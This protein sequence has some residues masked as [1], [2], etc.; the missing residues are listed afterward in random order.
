ME[1]P[2]LP[3][4]VIV[5]L[6]GHLPTLAA[7]RAAMLVCHQWRAAHT[8]LRSTRP[9]YWRS[10][11]MPVSAECT[12]PHKIKIRHSKAQTYHIFT[13]AHHGPM[14]QDTIQALPLDGRLF[15]TR[16]SPRSALSC[17]REGDLR[18]PWTW[19]QPLLFDSAWLLGDMQQLAAVC[20]KHM[21]CRMNDGDY[22]FTFKAAKTAAWKFHSR[23]EIY[24]KGRVHFTWRKSS[25]SFP[26]V[27]RWS[28]PSNFVRDLML[29]IS[30]HLAQ[31]LDGT[32]EA[33]YVTQWRDWADTY[34]FGLLEALHVYPF[35]PLDMQKEEYITLT[36]LS[37]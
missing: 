19:L 37:L 30:E 14:R 26:C 24:V 7:R 32:T 2:I 12:S 16:I 6:I 11:T 35:P 20:T 22:A 25:T 21:L 33:H 9:W 29:F 36:P 31:L 13:N 10:L 18:M 8:R 1:S 3:F 15:I 5:E 17:A 27:Q 28:N 23:I 4:D 34:P